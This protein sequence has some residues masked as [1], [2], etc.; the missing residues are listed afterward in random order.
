MKLSDRIREKIKRCRTCGGK[1]VYEGK[2]ASDITCPHCTD[3]K[4][5]LRGVV[6]LETERK[7]L[8]AATTEFLQASYEY[9]TDPD[10]F[11]KARRKIEALLKAH[12]IV[13]QFRKKN[14]MLAGEIK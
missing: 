6:A 9:T 1:G 7:K 14:L 5:S 3:W 10:R 11:L 4:T 13:Q 12:D 2:Y 8:I